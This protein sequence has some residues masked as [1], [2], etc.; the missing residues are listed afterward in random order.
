MH[1]GR[2]EG[3]SYTIR[4]SVVLDEAL[5]EHVRLRAFE[6]RMSRS[7]YVRALVASDMTTG[8]RDKG[9]AYADERAVR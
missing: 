4:L 2:G 9:A 3:I 8:R 6:T 7:A 1:G 5:S